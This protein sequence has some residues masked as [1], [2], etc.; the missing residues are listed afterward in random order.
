MATCKKPIVLG[1]SFWICAGGV[2][3]QNRKE[4]AKAV[5]KHVVQDGDSRE[6]IVDDLHCP[7]FW[8][9]LTQEKS[10]E[11]FAAIPGSPQP[12]RIS[13]S[14]SRTGFASYIF[15]KIFSQKPN[16]ADKG[17]HSWYAIHN[18]NPPEC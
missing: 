7:G 15:S 12:L 17:E 10:S 3:Q 6:V 5:T 18:Y 11:N 1:A 13:T 2:N 8:Q 9:T 16:K 4:N 14:I